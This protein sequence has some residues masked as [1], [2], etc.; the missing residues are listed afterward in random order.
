MMVK[1]IATK[2]HTFDG[3]V[4]QANEAFE[5]DER[6]AGTLVSLGRARRADEKSTEVKPTTTA[7]AAEPKPESK[8]GGKRTYKTRRTKAEDE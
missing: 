1:M 5:A 6:Y 3:R 4:I 8:Q 2:P 7:A